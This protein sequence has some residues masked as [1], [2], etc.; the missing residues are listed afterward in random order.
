MA[1][2][3][4]ALL[5][6][7]LVCACTWAVVIIYW[8]EIHLAPS[9][10]DVLLYLV[11]LP[12]TIWITFLVLRWLW[13][14]RAEKRAA[15]ALAP[16]LGAA[17]PSS[18]AAAPAEKLQVVAALALTPLGEEVAAIVEALK[19][20]PVPPLDAEL[21]DQN[22]FP[23]SARRYADLDLGLLPPDWSVDGEQP[24]PN[25]QAR[26]LAL[27]AALLT[28]LDQ[29]LAALAACQQAN[30]PAVPKQKSAELNPAWLGEISA[31]PEQVKTSYSVPARLQVQLLLEPGM[32]PALEAPLSSW[33]TRLLAQQGLNEQ[34]L[35]IELRSMPAKGLAKHLNALVD[36][37]APLKQPFAVLLLAA[38]STVCQDVIDQGVLLERSQNE[39]GMHFPGEAAAALLLA[40]TAFALPDAKALAQLGLSDLA[41]S[42][43]LARTRPH[44]A[45]AL[46]ALLERLTGR[47]SLPGE[48]AWVC[49]GLSLGPEA[50]EF[51]PLLTVA[52]AS[53]QVDEAL[54]LRGAMGDAGLAGRL[55]SFALASQTVAEQGKAA[56]LVL[57][58]GLQER[59]L[60]LL[61]VVPEPAQADAAA[62]SA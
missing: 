9:M 57:N 13:L 36:E 52:Q 34:Q 25:A 39:A 46:P 14:R 17:E 21:L 16:T 8:Q 43:P 20:E 45:K 2:F 30:A 48:L 61:D 49:S 23:L 56:L 59:G 38:G 19:A 15:A 29:P 60:C 41:E 22:G 44:A 31:A 26:A 3:L 11:A 58:D 5:L 18:P 27:L 12:L 55:A 7:A 4:R 53:I 35:Q 6:L 40:N 10:D 37:I 33:L 1:K 47:Q 24:L 51:A 50:V 32:D 28:R 54:H 62:A 42:D